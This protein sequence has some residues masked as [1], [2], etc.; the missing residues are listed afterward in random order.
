M[1][2]REEII[3]AAEEI[4]QSLPLPADLKKIKAER[5]RLASE[6]I[7]GETDK[8]LLIIGPCSAHESKPVLDYV[9]RLGKL[10]ERVKDKIVIIPRIYTNKPRTKGV[11]Y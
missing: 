9:E 10:N 11:V 3:P 8:L 1:F 7:R 5:D 4:L 6:V 2:K